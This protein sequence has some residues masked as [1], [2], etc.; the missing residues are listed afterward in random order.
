MR[1]MSGRAGIKRAGGHWEFFTQTEGAAHLL[2]PFFFLS[3]LQIKRLDP[4]NIRRILL[5][6][7]CGGGGGGGGG[8]TKARGEL[9]REI[10]RGAAWTRMLPGR[11]GSLTDVYLQ[12]YY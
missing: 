8:Q 4:L 7:K 2:P 9:C 1:L 10:C 11:A 5:G 3:V 6:K 12:T